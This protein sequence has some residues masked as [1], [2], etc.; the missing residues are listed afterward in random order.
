MSYA[1]LLVAHIDKESQQRWW[2][3]QP[4]FIRQDDYREGIDKLVVDMNQ[5]LS[6]SPSNPL[7][8]IISEEGK[9]VL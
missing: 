7:S 6:Q 8:T 4:L 5:S 2:R 3:R 9:G 1:Y